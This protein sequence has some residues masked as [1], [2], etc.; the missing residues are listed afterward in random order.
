MSIIDGYTRRGRR[1]LLELQR[2]PKQLGDDLRR[3][4]SR[5][6][7][8]GSCGTAFYLR[9]V[10]CVCAHGRRLAR[11]RSAARSRVLCDALARALR[12]ARARSAA[13]SRALSASARSRTLFVTCHLWEVAQLGDDGERHRVRLGQRAVVV[14]RPLEAL[15]FEEEEAALARAPQHERH[16]LVDAVPLSPKGGGE[17][18]SSFSASSSASVSNHR[19][20]PEVGVG[21]AGDM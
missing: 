14:E 3:R 9:S 18:S 2:E 1:A 13:R 8:V 19:Y 21:M 5:V 11:A 12:R 16:R 15:A 20:R 6:A 4:V 17:A 7:R 10:R